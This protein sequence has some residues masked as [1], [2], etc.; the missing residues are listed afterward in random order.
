MENE[1]DKNLLE[2]LDCFD[3]NL[4]PFIPFLLQDLWEIGSSSKKIKQV[5]VEH[6]LDKHELKILDVGCGKGGISIPIA[7]E[8]NSTL[9]GI[10][11][12][13]EFIEFAMQKAVE[14]NIHENC[15]FVCG[16]AKK[17]VD[18]LNG[19]NLVLLASVGPI[20]GNVYGTLSTLENA[21]DKNGYVILDDCYLPDDAVSEY[22]R[23]LR[24]SDF[25]D[26]INRSN[27]SLIAE[28]IQS[29]NDTKEEDDFI[30]SS[31]E[32][33]VI[34]LSSIHPEKKQLFYSYLAM[35]R[36]EN[37]SLEKELQCVALL[38]MKKN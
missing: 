31:I 23:C 16:D 19:F 33:R 29:P 36:K 30:Y 27:Y 8:Y 22:D 35:Q 17:I 24:E 7:K 32:K 4:R 6:G 2:A 21:L 26:Q 1:F 18:G 15:T 20:L 38:L 37:Y 11:G 13:P 34:E 10:D 3:P 28:Y 25:Y 5:I 14:Y 9:V 12:M